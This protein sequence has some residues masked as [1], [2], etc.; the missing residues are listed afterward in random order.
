MGD[1]R[2][3]KH[4][5][6][7]QFATGRSV[8]RPL[9]S[10]K[11]K[12]KDNLKRCNIPFSSWENKASERR[13]WRQSCFSSV[14]RFDQSRLQH[15]SQLHASMKACWQNAAP[16]N[17][18]LTYHCAFVARSKACLAVP[19]RKHIVNDPQ[20]VPFAK[21]FARHQQLSRNTIVSIE[22]DQCFVLLN[23]HL[24]F[25]SRESI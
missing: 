9:L 14:Q 11:D 20:L 7:G 10:F 18:I 19:S 8:G 25:T 23:L 15:W 5:H 4:L 17:G 3:L 1:I 24:S 6:F 12:L 21:W 13:T 16:L 2:I 22:H